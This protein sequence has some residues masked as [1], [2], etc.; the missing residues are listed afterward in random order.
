MLSRAVSAPPACA[1][2]E[3]RWLPPLPLLPP[4]PARPLLRC[5]LLL[6]LSPV[7]GASAAGC[8]ML[9]SVCRAAACCL[10]C[11]VSTRLRCRTVPLVRS[12]CFEA[13]CSIMLRFTVTPPLPAEVALPAAAPPAPPPLLAVPLLLLA[14]D[15]A[16]ALPSTSSL[17][18]SMARSETW[19]DVVGG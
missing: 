5:V 19:R 15:A 2:A 7:A 3:R 14:A 16:A 18:I 17:A 11:G 13:A 1:A 4:L 10:S 12:L 9:A 8:C 6:L